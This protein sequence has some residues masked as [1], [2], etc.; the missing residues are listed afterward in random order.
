MALD[1]RE[2][3]PAVLTAIRP[4]SDDDEIPIRAMKQVPGSRR[5]KDMHAPI[6]PIKP[7]ATA[8]LWRVAMVILAVVLIFVFFP[9]VLAVQAAAR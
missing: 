5:L 3:P 4:G 8:A 7:I 2:I 1:G 6:Q 9:A